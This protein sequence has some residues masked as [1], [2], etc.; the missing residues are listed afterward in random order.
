METFTWSNRAGLDTVKVIADVLNQVKESDEANNDKMVTYSTATPDLIVQSITWSPANPSENSTVTFTVTI[1]NQGIG[2]ASSSY[3]AY[4]V[5]DI[6]QTSAYVSQ[7]NPGATA[8]QTF[9]W[10]AAAGSHTVKA[11][12][13]SSNKLAESDETNNDKTAAMSFLAP[14]L[15]IL[16]ITPSSTSPL[17]GLGV[18]FT[19]NIKN[20]G[21]SGADYFRIHYYIDGS[22][23]GYQGVQE[24]AAGAT[25]TKTYLWT[26][27]AGSHTIEVVADAEN[28]VNESNESNNV[29]TTTVN[30]SSPL[31]PDLIIQDIVWSPENPSTGDI[32]TFTVTIKNQGSGKA[33]A[34]PIA[35]YIDDTYQDSAHI[36]Q[37]DPG[38]ITTQTFTWTATASSHTVKV[39]ADYNN[40]ITESNETNN[41]KTLDFSVLIPPAPDLVIQGIDWSPVSPS[42]GDTVCFTMTIKNQGND[43]ASGSYISYYI[44]GDYRGYHEVQ[45]IAAGDIVTKAFTW[46]YLAGSHIFKVVVDM[47]SEVPES[48]ESNNERMVTFPAPDLVIEKITWSPVNPSENS[49]VTFTVTIKNQGGGQ[50]SSLPV[51][52]YIDDTHQTSVHINQIDPGATATQTF[53]WTATA[54]SH[55]VKAVAD[56]VNSI[57]EIDESNNEKAITLSAFLPLASAPAPAPASEVTPVPATIPEQQEPDALL[58][59]KSSEESPGEDTAVTLPEEPPSAPPSWL[60][61]VLKLWWV[62]AA[63][64]VCSISAIVILRLRRRPH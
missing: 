20:Q 62:A 23:Q 50:A 35:C 33:I 61:I 22:Y 10:T 46:D 28:H 12:A 18:T 9:T 36:N 52:Y 5:D 4:Y 41:E 39:I 55:T 29:K 38:A 40:I 19:V 59:E 2:R 8:T 34:L 54:G 6:C 48:N 7:M 1:K 51:A 24:I 45:E 63:A 25:V 37:I 44:D 13:D 56:G 30:S 11:V 17:I 53:T 21:R 60:E 14:D 27:Q 47:E 42:I 64:V 32:L 57:T 49:T 43:G 58:D 16:D 15:V 26:A 31:P 3:V